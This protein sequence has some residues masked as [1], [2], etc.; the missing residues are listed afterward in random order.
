MTAADETRPIGFPEGFVSRLRK[1]IPHGKDPLLDSAI[2]RRQLHEVLRQL[3]S[4]KDV[5]RPATTWEHLAIELIYLSVSPGHCT[6]DTTQLLQEIAEKAE[7]TRL[8]NELQQT[9]YGRTS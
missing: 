6:T 9:V 1:I 5:R 3:H 4:Y 7:I 8:Y 2:R